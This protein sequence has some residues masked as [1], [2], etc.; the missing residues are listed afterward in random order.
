METVLLQTTTI[1]FH[2]NSISVSQQCST[3]HTFSIGSRLSF[4]VTKACYIWF[5]QKYPLQII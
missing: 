3:S 2:E 4:K 1:L 5:H